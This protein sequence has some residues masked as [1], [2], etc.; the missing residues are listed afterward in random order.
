MLGRQRRLKT[1]RHRWKEQLVYLAVL[2]LFIK[3]N[4]GGN[5]VYSDVVNNGW[6]RTYKPV[7]TMK[8]FHRLHQKFDA[9]TSRFILVCSAAY[10]CRIERRDCRVTRQ[11][12]KVDKFILMDTIAN[13]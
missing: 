3:Q 7:Y 5:M 12:E 1:R 6:V 9:V 8:D 10:Y 4:L 11:L 2:F 13:E